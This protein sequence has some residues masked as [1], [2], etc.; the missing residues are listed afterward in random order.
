M[1]RLFS[2]SNSLKLVVLGGRIVSL[3]VLGEAVMRELREFTRW[4][5]RNHPHLHLR[6]INAAFC[7]DWVSQMREQIDFLNSEPA[8]GDQFPWLFLY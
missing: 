2:C 7:Q 8:H 5:D 4:R 3:S 1:K 6:E